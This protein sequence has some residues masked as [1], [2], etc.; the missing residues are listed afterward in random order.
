MV[1]FRQEKEMGEKTNLNYLLGMS[2]F[3]VLILHTVATGRVTTVDDDGPADFNTIQ[4]AIDD[5]NDGDIVI[6]APGEYKESISYYGKAII[7]KSEAGPYHT[8]IRATGGSVVTFNSGETQ[9]AVLEGFTLTG[10]TGT[11]HNWIMSGG[12]IFCINGSSPKIARNI[13]TANTAEGG[14][15]GPGAGGGAI[16]CENSHIA[17]VGNIITKNSTHSSGGAICS[18]NSQPIIA[19]NTIIENSCWYGGGISSQNSEPIIINSIIYRNTPT[20]LS[21]IQPSQVF[22][23]NISQE[24]FDG[25]NGN[26]SED[27]IFLDQETGNFHLLP[28][29]PCIDAGTNDI[30][31][32]LLIDIDSKPRIW[33]GD[34]DSISVADIGAYELYV[35]TREAPNILYKPKVDFGSAIL[36]E[37][38]LQKMARVWNMGAQNLLIESIRIEAADACDFRWFTKEPLPISVSLLKYVD[39]YLEFCPT[40]PGKTSWAEVA[41]LSNDPNQPCSRI[42]LRGHLQGVIHVPRDYTTI[43][44]AIDASE[45]SDIIIVAEGTYYENISF[46]GKKIKLISEEGPYGATIDGSR[47][48]TVVSI[49][50]DAIVSGFRITHGEGWSGGIYCSGSNIEISGN[51]IEENESDPGEG[52]GIYCGGTN[53]IIKENTIKNNETVDGSGGGIY[54]DG[55]NVRIENNFISNNRGGMGGGVLCRGGHI[56]IKG[57][58]IMGNLGIHGG[59]IYCCGSNET[60]TNNI[61]FRNSASGGGGLGYGGNPN[62][63]C[64]GN[65]IVENW[66]YH[67]GGICCEGIY[68]GDIS[69]IKNCIVYGNTAEHGNDLF[70]DYA[71]W[72]GGPDSIPSQLFYSLLSQPEY[73]GINNNICADPLFIDPENNDYR[74]QLNSPCI[75]SGDPNS[76]LDPDFTRADIGAIYFEQSTC[77]R[78]DLYHD[79]FINLKDYA[80]FANNWLKTGEGILGDIYEDNKVEYK[81]LEILADN[82]LYGC[83]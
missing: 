82:W 62:F 20:D 34:L 59:G 22:Y 39:I 53:I 27:P 13:I 33:D 25:I 78:S 5:A 18:I 11:R 51:L 43:Q 4:A 80:I 48:G 68:E 60:I 6:V 83:D 77:N 8:V 2:I 23:S 73:C 45:N 29:S 63:I 70:D 38:Y 42:S 19:N 79:D 54:C 24:G 30:T 52:G 44:A 67:G 74:L 56:N 15:V 37:S 40:T 12:A 81:D 16:Y 36:A 72:Y 75:D 66:A 76:P 58:I 61:I 31:I 69:I 3:L 71:F 32:D 1:C 46:N 21:G 47:R 64:I 55:S 35:P 41:I 65:T 28:D 14:G 57:N 7:L 10:G 26:I 9:E 50:S 49:G 17:I